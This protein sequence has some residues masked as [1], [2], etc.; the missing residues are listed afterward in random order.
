[1]DANNV[2]IRLSM[3]NTP[4]KEED[5]FNEAT[6]LLNQSVQSGLIL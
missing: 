3:V 5:G 4:G 1:M 2:R 6:N